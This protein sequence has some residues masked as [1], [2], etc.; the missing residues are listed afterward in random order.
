MSMK[1]DFVVNNL[2]DAQR[3]IRF[4]DSAALALLILDSL[5]LAI[6]VFGFAG[7]PLSQMIRNLVEQDVLWYAALIIASF[8]VFAM[9]LVAHI[10]LIV[11][12][13]LPID[14]AGAHVAVGDDVDI[15]LVNLNRFDSFERIMPSVHEYWNE[16]DAMGEGDI[17]SEFI[18]EL[19]K[20]AYIRRIK[21]NRLANSFLFQ[22]GIVIGIA[23]V[24]FVL[25]FAGLLVQ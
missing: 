15:R 6:V 10:L 18:Y 25:A 5:L 19:H 22:L 4:L 3:G 17:A 1:I 23:V 11:R 13:L 20:F 14:D 7:G 9:S 8:A 16:L 21:T 24:G 2:N 12:A